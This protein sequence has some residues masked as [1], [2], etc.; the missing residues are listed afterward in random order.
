MKYCFNISRTMNVSFEKSKELF[1]NFSK[2]IFTLTVIAIILV[3]LYQIYT[4]VIRK[5][6]RSAEYL[7]L[8]NAES[9]G[10][11]VIASGE[12]DYLSGKKEEEECK[13]NI[14]VKESFFSKIFS[15]IFGNSK[16]KFNGAIKKSVS[17]P[18]DQ[19]SY[20]IILN[21]RINDYVENLGYWK[22]ILHKGTYQK[23]D[24]DWKFDTWDKVITH[25]PIQNPGLWLHPATNTIRF[26]LN[27]TS[28]YKYL[29]IP[30][31]GDGMTYFGED[32]IISSISRRDKAME[33]IRKEYNSPQTQLEYI[34]IPNIAVNRD[35][36]LTIIVDRTSITVLKNGKNYLFTQLKGLPKINPGPITVHNKTTYNGKIKELSILPFP[37]DKKNK[38]NF[39]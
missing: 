22:H 12:L 14:T 24:E 23:D 21:I 15:S 39:L 11:T 25:V 38:K 28:Y 37:L 18:Y 2:P 20:T 13:I 35:V 31:H 27:T 32:R 4:R 19:Y 6:I 5:K 29:S 30:E 8:S 36:N 3:I 34:D 1:Q 33:A 26:C 10:I 9:A 7:L 17:D 16:K